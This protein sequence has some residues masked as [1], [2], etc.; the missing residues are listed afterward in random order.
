MRFIDIKTDGGVLKGKIAFYCEERFHIPYSS[1]FEEGTKITWRYPDI[2]REDLD[3]GDNISISFM[4]GV[5]ETC[6]A[7]YEG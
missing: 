7:L 6:C 5:L 2:L 1:R 3:V 4:G